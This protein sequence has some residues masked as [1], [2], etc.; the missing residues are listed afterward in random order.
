MDGNLGHLLLLPE[1]LMNCNGRTKSITPPKGVV[2]SLTGEYL[3][4]QGTVIHSFG[5][6]T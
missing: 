6:P 2:T 4:E 1:Y 3:E 5:L